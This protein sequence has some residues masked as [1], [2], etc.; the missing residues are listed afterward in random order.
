MALS[1]FELVETI[2]KG[3]FGRVIKVALRKEGSDLNGH[4][5][6][7]KVIKKPAETATDEIHHA[8]EERTILEYVQHPLIVGLWAAFQREKHLYLVLD[9]L[10]GGDLGHLLMNAG[11]LAEKQARFYAAGTVLALEHLHKHKIIYRDLKPANILLDADGQVC[12][13]D[14]GLSKD[15]V[16][17]SAVTICGTPEY[18]A[19]EILE[20][21]GHGRMVDWWS[22]GILL[23]D[24][25]CGRPPFEARNNKRLFEKILREDVF[26]P[27]FL[28]WPAQD[29][30]RKLLVRNPA[31]RLGINGVDEIRN[32]AFFRTVQW[33]QLLQKKVAAPYKPMPPNVRDKEIPAALV[34]GGK[35][36]PRAGEGIFPG[37]TFV[38]DDASNVLPA[39]TTE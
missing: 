3:S 1:D 2:G 8:K 4:I 21:K 24:M 13:T 35:S 37:F 28:S 36:V 38:A 25:M 6:A 5:F 19:P 26:I 16:K 15:I 32:H 39:P 12:I 9:Y 27:R 34:E 7:M 11:I 31:L 29:I 17:G 10:P 18:I 30:L 33:T 22:L 23:Y 14:F 20:R